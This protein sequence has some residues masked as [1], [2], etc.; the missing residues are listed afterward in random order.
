[1]GDGFGDFINE[2]LENTLLEKFWQ[3]ITLMSQEVFLKMGV[4]WDIFL[5]KLA[6]I[7]IN[8]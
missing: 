8:I 5:D 2:S 3:I 4:D 7:V 6:E 1:M